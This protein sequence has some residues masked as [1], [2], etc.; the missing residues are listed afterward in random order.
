MMLWQCIIYFHP[1]GKK[2]CRRTF[3][4]SKKIMKNLPLL[5]SSIKRLFFIVFNKNTKNFDYIFTIY[6]AFTRNVNWVG[7]I[8]QDLHSFLARQRQG[9]KTIGFIS[10]TVT[11][12]LCVHHKV[13]SIFLWRSLHDYGVKSSSSTFNGGLENVNIRRRILIF[14]KPGYSP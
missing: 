4:K 8:N 1:L 2:Q 10:N 14:L 11:T 7:C 6:L 12:A 13:F 9:Q 5:S 3:E